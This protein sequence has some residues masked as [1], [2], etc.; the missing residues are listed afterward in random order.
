MK[1]HLRDSREFKRVY[2]KGRRYDGS[3]L[4]AFVLR[5][6]RTQHRLGITVSKKT[7]N[8]AVDRNRAKRLLRESFRLCHSSLA[9]LGNRYDWVLNGK[10]K[11]V[12]SKLA[13][14]LSDLDGVIARVVVDEGQHQ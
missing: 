5:N 12:V 4:T 3:L 8:R 11:L 6:D 13:Q 9:R 2:E 7:A 14:S 10:R 1:D